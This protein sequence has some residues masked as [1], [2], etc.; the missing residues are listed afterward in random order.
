MV[1]VSEKDLKEFRAPRDQ[2]GHQDHKVPLG[3]QARGYQGSQ[4]S[5]GHLVL[6]AT[7]ELENPACQGYLEN[8]EDRGY[9][10]NEVTSALLEGRGQLGSLGLQ[11]SQVLLDFLEVQN[12]EFKGCLDSQVNLGS[13]AKKVY[14]VLLV[15]LDSGETK[16]L[17]YQVYQV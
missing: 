3:Y 11:G 8:L 2:Q 7:K 16:E 15:L 10:D 6:R 14:L 1:R 17:V 5:Q 4:E 13:L 9:Q 12:Q